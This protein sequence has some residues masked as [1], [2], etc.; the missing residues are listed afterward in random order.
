M[1]NFDGF[2]DVP[3]SERSLAIACTRGRQAVVACFG[4]LLSEADVS[5][6]QWRVM[7]VLGDFSPI[8]LSELCEKT[9]IHKV[10]MTRIVRIL[11]KRDYLEIARD[12]H[13]RRTLNVSITPEGMAFNSRYAAEAS[14]ISREINRR[15]GMEKSLL[16]LV[17]LDDLSKLSIND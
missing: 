13:D 2:W 5:E 9:C 3:Y 11:S 16:L 14:R 12:S 4:E 17:L 15:F 1:I 7:R 10:S 6:Q 8:G